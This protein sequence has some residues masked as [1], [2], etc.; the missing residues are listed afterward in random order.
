MEGSD[1]KADSSF[2]W[3]MIEHEWM[4]T[5]DQTGEGWR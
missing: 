5:L 1:T 2:R 3:S 4:L